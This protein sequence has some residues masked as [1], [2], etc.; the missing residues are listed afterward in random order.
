MRG[1]SVIGLV[2]GLCQMLVASVESRN[3]LALAPGH[4][5][6]TMSQKP[7][8]SVEAVGAMTTGRAKLVTLLTGP[9]RGH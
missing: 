2:K 1:S 9:E 4:E 6:L 8:V 7:V 5:T 3:E